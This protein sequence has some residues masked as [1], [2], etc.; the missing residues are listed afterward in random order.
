MADD[1]LVLVLYSSL[2][3][4]KT[5]WIALVVG[6]VMLLLFFVSF[7]QRQNIVWIFLFAA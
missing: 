1:C 3:V 2:T 6:K 5:L 7:S 4:Y